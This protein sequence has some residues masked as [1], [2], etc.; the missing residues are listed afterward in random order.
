MQPHRLSR[1]HARRESRKLAVLVEDP[2]HLP[3][4]RVHIRG[5]NVFVDAKDRLE[6]LD[7]LPREA[8]ELPLAERPRVY[9]DAALCS[10]ERDVHDGRLPRHQTGQ[11]PHVVDIDL[12]MEAEAAFEGPAVVRVLH[13]V[14]AERL[15]LARVFEELKLDADFPNGREEHFPKLL[16]VFEVILRERERSV[17]ANEA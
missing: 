1:D 3:S 17:S 10:S 8:L 12:G 2:R 11:A 7:E 4:P 16:G 13:A 14:R 6:G 15:D 5:R 9:R